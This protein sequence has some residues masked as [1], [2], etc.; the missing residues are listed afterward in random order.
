MLT[1]QDVVQKSTRYLEQK[2]V[3]N[4]RRQAEEVISD[5]FNLKRLELYMD[6]ERPLS[7]PEIVKCRSVIERRGK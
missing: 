1:L 4:P 6:F 7:E 5:A 2:G 3:E